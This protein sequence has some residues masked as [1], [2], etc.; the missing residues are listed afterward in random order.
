MCLRLLNSSLTMHSVTILFSLVKSKVRGYAKHNSSHPQ[1]TSVLLIVL[2]VAPGSPSPKSFFLLSKNLENFPLRSEQEGP[3]GGALLPHGP[4]F[5]CAVCTFSLC[6]HGFYPG[7]PASCH[8]PNIHT[9][10]RSERQDEDGSAIKRQLLQGV[11]IKT[12]QNQNF[13]GCLYLS[14]SVA[15]KITRVHQGVDTLDCEMCA[16]AS[17][18]LCNYSHCQG[19]KTGVLYSRFKLCW[20]SLIGIHTPQ[21]GDYLRCSVCNSSGRLAIRAVPAAHGSSR[22]LFLAECD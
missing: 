7:S 8:T 20:E 18:L 10:V 1:T 9:W 17:G 13:I 22:R 5:L 12:E 11:K 14:F 16:A 3:R 4:N 6:L 21:A 15:Q 2:R 19:K